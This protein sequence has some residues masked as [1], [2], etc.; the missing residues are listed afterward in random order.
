MRYKSWNWNLN[1]FWFIPSIGKTDWRTWPD[2]LLSRIFVAKWG[3]EG[4]TGGADVGQAPFFPGLAKF[5]SLPPE[6]CRS[7]L[8]C[9]AWFQNLRCQ[10]FSLILA[11]KKCHFWLRIWQKLADVQLSKLAFCCPRCIAETQ[12]IFYK[13][14]LWWAPASLRKTLKH[15]K[16][17]PPKTPPTKTRKHIHFHQMNLWDAWFFGFNVKFFF[18]WS[19]LTLVLSKNVWDFRC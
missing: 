12:R 17:F 6:L 7:W 2:F 1:E 14:H 16:I 18:M 10:A 4:F 9:I 8:F 3:A 5:L 15:F 19:R 11:A 13:I